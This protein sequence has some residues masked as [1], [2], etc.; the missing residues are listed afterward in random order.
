MILRGRYSDLHITDLLHSLTWSSLS[1]RRLF[2]LNAIMF[3]S[4]N[5]L[6]PNYLSAR[7]SRV[8]DRHRHGTRLS[9]SNRLVPPKP[10]TNSGKR[11]FKYRGVLSFNSLAVD[12][13]EA[14]DFSDFR[15]RYW[16]A[17]GSGTSAA[18]G[19]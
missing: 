2:H 6:T 13:T 3:K 15:R 17:V 16:R 7:F 4:L 18:S 14:S 1:E 8:R 9:T 19:S 11:S 10:K 5:G 12:V